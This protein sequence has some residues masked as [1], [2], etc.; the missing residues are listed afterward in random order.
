MLDFRIGVVNDKSG[1]AM[2]RKPIDGM[3]RIREV[4]TFYLHTQ[5]VSYIALH[6]SDIVRFS[7]EA[8]SKIFTKSSS[9]RHDRDSITGSSLTP[10]IH[11][12]ILH[13]PN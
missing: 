7:S 1:K 11:L 2:K 5:H 4:Y 3:D 6:A 12:F 13:E 8:G 9:S 10:S